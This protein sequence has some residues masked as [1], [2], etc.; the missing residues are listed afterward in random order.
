MLA[1]LQANED[2]PTALSFENQG[3]LR[4]AKNLIFHEQTKHIDVHCHSIQK[5]VEDGEAKLKY[6]PTQNQTADNITKSLGPNKFVKFSD[7]LGLVSK[8]TSKGR[9]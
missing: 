9:C 4:I 1:N 5:L 7:K 3:V 6:C 2:E 8:M